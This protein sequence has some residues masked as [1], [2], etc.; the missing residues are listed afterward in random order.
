MALVFSVLRKVALPSTSPQRV[1]G[2][3]VV[4]R[5]LAL[6]PAGFREDLGGL[7]HSALLPA[8]LQRLS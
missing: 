2:G 8:G 5:W 1:V 7:R 6:S 3:D 4:Q